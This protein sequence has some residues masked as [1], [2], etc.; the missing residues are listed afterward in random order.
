[1]ARFLKTFRKH[2]K[3]WLAVLTLLAMFSFVFLGSVGSISDL[4]LERSGRRN[5]VVVKTTKYGSIHESQLNYMLRQRGAL[6]SFLRQLQVAVVSKGG[7]AEQVRAA[8]MAL[9]DSPVSEEAAV[10]D[11]LIMQKAEELG[12]RV[13]EKAVN[14]Y[15][16]SLTE[17][18]VGNEDVKRIL[19]SLHLGQTQLFEMLRQELLARRLKDMFWVSLM[20][21]TPAQRWEYFLELNRRAKIEAVPIPVTKFVAQVLDPPETAL[22]E[23]F[24]KYKEKLPDP[25]S[26]EPGFKEPHRIDVEYFKARY[27][28]FIDPAAVTDQAIREFYEANKER[29]YRD[30]L[31]E[32]PKTEPPKTEAP[33]TEAPKTEPAKTEPAKTQAP[34]Q[35]E[36]K[37]QAPAQPPAKTEAGKA[38]AAKTEAGKTG[39]A[40]SKPVAP[41]PAKASPPKSAPGKTSA[42]PRR[43]PFRF[44]S[45]QKVGPGQPAPKA[46]PPATQA[47]PSTPKTESAA[48]AP[49]A[50]S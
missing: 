23:F 26:P 27:E 43:S 50:A 38:G 30:L 1:M 8:L 11:W 45:E 12:L 18:K 25:G 40:K 47:G 16:A 13:S 17:G 41:E 20:A 42:A 24:E 49:P 22:R 28:S 10:D 15:L 3:A 48:P 39:A 44:V 29:L 19:K 46:Q 6:H 34:K 5:P 32:E 31:P 7:R 4:W 35:G 14:D 33:K 2:R 21:A 37:R 36:A 9:G